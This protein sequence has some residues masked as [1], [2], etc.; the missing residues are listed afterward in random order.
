MID[1]RETQEYLLLEIHAR[2]MQGRESGHD[3]A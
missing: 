1:C 3:V 2:D